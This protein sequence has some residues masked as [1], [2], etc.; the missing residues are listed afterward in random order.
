MQSDTT[1]DN[2][3]PFGAQASAHMRG[4]EHLRRVDRLIEA[5]LDLPREARERF[6]EQSCI[7]D[8]ELERDAKRLL[9]SC[10]HVH[11]SAK[12]LEG[13]AAEMAALTTCQAG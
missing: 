6:L 1:R 7:G 9:T 8:A 12:F 3:L 4:V 13:T 5:A 10:E 2:A 11:D